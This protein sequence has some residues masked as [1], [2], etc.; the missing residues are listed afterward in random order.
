M[1][2]QLPARID[3]T[4]IIGDVRAH[5]VPTLMAAAGERASL[6]F[7]EFFAGR[8][9]NLNTRRAYGRAVAEFLAWCDDNRCPRSQR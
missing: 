3:R 9:R 7:L 6:R 2:E 4:E 8:I 5:I 1:S